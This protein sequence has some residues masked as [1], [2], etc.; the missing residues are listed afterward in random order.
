MANFDY[1]CPHN[2]MSIQQEENI[3]HPDMTDK[4]RGQTAPQE[5]EYVLFDDRDV[6]RNIEYN[7][8]LDE[9]QKYITDQF[10]DGDLPHLIVREIG[11]AQKIQFEMKLITTEPVTRGQ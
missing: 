11:P 1:A 9:I 8:T 2:G 7:G 4:A 6:T 10:N 5:K 3:M